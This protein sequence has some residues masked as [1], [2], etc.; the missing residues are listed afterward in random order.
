MKKLLVPVILLLPLL[1][2]AQS[3]LT[4]GGVIDTTLKNNYDI[5]I[6]K[7][8]TEIDRISNTYG[9]AG[10][11]PTV[12][13]TVAGNASVANLN[14]QLNTGKNTVKNGVTNKSFSS[15]VSASMMLFNGFMITS[16]KKQLD[17]LQKQGELQLNVQIQNSL[18][19]VMTMYYDILRQQSYLKII[20][21]SIDV[22]AKKLEIVRNRYDV[23]MANEAD[24]LQAQMDLNSAEQDLKGQQLVIDNSKTGLLQLMGVKHFYPYN[25]SDSII[26]DKGIQ[27]DALVSYI[28]NN[29]EYLSAVEQIHINEQ[30][31]MQKKAVRYPSIRVNTSY[32]FT[33]SGNSASLN[34]LTKSFGP[35]V[36]ATMQI[37]I[38]NG[39]I[40]RTQ[41]RVAEFNVKNAE[42]EKENVL[43][44]LKADVIKTYDSF[45]S[46]LQQIITQQAS[47]EKAV[48]LVN[49]VVQRFRL[50]Q[51][52]ILDVKAAQ[53]SF[54]AA[55][56]TLVNLQYSAKIA[57]IE[58]KRLLSKLGN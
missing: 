22:S 27:K 8:N 31:V 20:Q 23:G 32:N 12:S 53:S 11:L 6:A 17:Y 16:T 9:F 47:Y 18:A 37:P 52:T 38:F 3:S 29:P 13:S 44:G 21:S 55:G 50:N 58:L 33:Y 28:E 15:N 4:L 35:A 48:K 43:T 39:T 49:I 36:G 40:S 10:G 26:V 1:S 25:I 45:E 41:Q 56:N 30:I 54:E 42:L 24:L 14:Q 2:A 7:N 57:E 34:L 19:A 5:Q 51:S 46:T